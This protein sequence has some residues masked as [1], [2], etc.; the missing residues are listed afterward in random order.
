MATSTAG[1]SGSIDGKGGSNTLDLSAAAGPVT[2]NLQTHKASPVG[3]TWANVGNFVGDNATST[4]VGANVTNTW[5]IAATNAGKVGS[6]AFT[7]FANLTGGSGNDV[8]TL[9]N[10]VG[11]SGT[12]DG[13]G[14]TNTL[15]DSA[16][17]SGVV[18]NLLLGTAT[19]V[20]AI[21]SIENSKSGT[22]NSILVGN[23]AA[24]VL[25]AVGGNNLII[26]G[27]GGDTVTGGTGSD[28]L[29]A[30]T[31]SYDQNP[32][33]LAA[34]LNVW[35][36]TS[37]SYA[38]RVAAVMSSSFQYHLDTTTVFDDGAPDK[39]TGGPG[40]SLFFAHIGGTSG[41]TTNARSGETVVH[42]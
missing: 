29:I 8:F 33:A 30:G 19:N 10:G 18:I 28:I 34:I 1:V 4:L 21:A 35:A 37:N 27:A 16:Y 41:D 17:Q 36:N 42:I 31:T 9:A 26:G 23:A 2:D 24:N 7:G 32:T 38:A 39:L 3:G 6:V 40:L 11:V 25:T 20:G 15:D 13:G 14:G 12:I 22:G 5:T